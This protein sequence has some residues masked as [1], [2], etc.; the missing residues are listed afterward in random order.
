MALTFGIYPGGLAGD[1]TGI[2]PGPPE[3]PGPIAAALDELGV[4]LVRGYV[5]YTDA[6]PGTV[7]APPAPW[8][9]ATD[10]RRLDLVVCFREPGADLSGWLDYLRYLLREHGEELACLQVGEEA[11]HAG[12]G[13]DGGAAAVREAI[14]QGVVAA[15]AEAVRLGLPVKIG[16]NSTPIFDPEQ[17]F[18]TDLGRR[19]G[20]PF[21]AAL[22]YVAFDFF[23]D[24]ARPIALERL[25]EAVT[26]VLTGFREQSLA[27]AGIAPSVPIHIGEHGWGTGPDR[28]EAKQVQVIDTVVRT[29]DA[30]GPQLNLDTYEHFALRDFDS[31]DPDPFRQ[32]GLLRSD[33]SPKP[34]FAHFRKLVAELRTAPASALT[35]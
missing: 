31:A 1:E 32:L 14:V 15:K 24:M 20:D 6:A 17:E 13:G 8:R 10:G 34:A 11:N 35:D 22:D 23:P 28:P 30:L 25:A 21:R 26:A 18:W 2:W 3:Q 33:Y 12:P 5:L 16:C 7:E 27:A 29:V 9:Y 19:G 4:R